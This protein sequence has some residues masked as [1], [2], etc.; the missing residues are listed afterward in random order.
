MDPKQLLLGLAAVLRDERSSNGWSQEKLAEQAGVHR[1]Y[2]GTIERAEQAPTITTVTLIS[3]ALDL[4]VS[5]L[6]AKA[7]ERAK[8]N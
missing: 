7:E 6:L 4:E 5:E 3:N 8:A 1:N 2:V